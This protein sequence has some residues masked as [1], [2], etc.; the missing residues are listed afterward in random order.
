[1]QDFDR[2]AVI[3]ISFGNGAKLQARHLLIVKAGVT[4]SSLRKRVGL[5]HFCAQPRPSLGLLLDSTTHVSLWTYYLSGPQSAALVHLAAVVFPVARFSA[6][7]CSGS[8]GYVSGADRGTGTPSRD[9]D[10]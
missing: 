7:G 6:R 4:P 8:V 3:A 2:L 1:V 9:T 5:Q 10:T